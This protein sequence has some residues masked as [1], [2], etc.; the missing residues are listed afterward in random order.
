MSLY[1]PDCQI[2]LQSYSWAE[3]ICVDPITDSEI[4]AVPLDLVDQQYCFL[5]IQVGGLIDKATLKSPRSIFTFHFI[6]KLLL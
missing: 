2:F 3:N 1:N 4:S 6:I 5:Q